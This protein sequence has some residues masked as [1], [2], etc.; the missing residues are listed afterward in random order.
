MYS[1]EEFAERYKAFSNPELLKILHNPSQYQPASIL[2]ARAEF[3]SRQLPDEDIDEAEKILSEEKERS[4]KESLLKKK[5]T[6]AGNVIYENINPVQENITSE[7]KRIRIIAIA[8]TCLFIYEIYR[9]FYLIKYIFAGHEEI[10]F[11]FT[12]IIFPLLVEGAGTA[13]FWMKKQTGWMLMAFFSSYSF[14]AT[15]YAIYNYFKYEFFGDHSAYFSSRVSFG[16]YLFNI[17]VYGGTLFA[18]SRPGIKEIFCINKNKLQGSI[19]AGVLF[20]LFL[21]VLV[22]WS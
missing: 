3:D 2:A 5:L 7:E 19:I 1:Q 9:N 4:G 12:I 21:I 16:P 17:I 11:G 10:K 8:F 20:G 15:L 18:L 22:S 14:M 13:L 6:G